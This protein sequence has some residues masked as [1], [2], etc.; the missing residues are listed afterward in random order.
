MLKAVLFDVDG[1]CG[2]ASAWA[3][4]LRGAIAIYDGPWDPLAHIEASPL[5]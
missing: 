5:A 1:T 3:A 2:E 4:D